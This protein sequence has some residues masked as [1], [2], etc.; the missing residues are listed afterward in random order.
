MVE[1][2]FT[3]YKTTEIR[4]TSELACLP[5]PSD[6]ELSDKLDPKSK[7]LSSQGYEQYSIKIERGPMAQAPP[8]TPGAQAAVQ[9]HNNA[10]MEAN[11][12][13]WGYTKCALMFFASLMITWVRS[14]FPP[15]TILHTCL[16]FTNPPPTQVPSS[17][18]R[19]YSLVHPGPAWWPLAYAAGLVLPLM[20]FWN[21]VIYVITS[22]SVVKSFFPPS[23]P[24]L[25]SRRGLKVQGPRMGRPRTLRC[26]EEGELARMKSPASV[27]DSTT[28]LRREKG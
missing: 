25:S 16:S 26:L 9:R 1:N 13:A 27:S 18:F 4:V 19:V 21:F 23:L 7:G 3:S 28:G 20:G 2:P 17:A 10:A 12:A 24:R 5:T 22:W 8:P 14:S 11:T 6:T 15:C